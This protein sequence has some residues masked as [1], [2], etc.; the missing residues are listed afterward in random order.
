VKVHDTLNR[1][2]RYVSHSTGKHVTRQ[3]SD[4]SIL[5]V[6]HRF[7][8]QTTEA[9]FQL[10]HPLY[11]HRRSLLY[12]L[13]YLRNE[14]NSDYGGPL[15]FYPPQQRRGATMPDNNYMVYDILPRGERLLK[16]ALLYREHHPTTNGYEWKH[17]FMAV[18]IMASVAIGAKGVCEFIYPDE[19]LVDLPRCFDVPP[20]QYIS[21][22][23]EEKIRPDA[24]LRPDGFFALRYENGIKRIFLLEADCHTEPY[25]SDN[26]ERKSLKHTILAYYAL[27]SNGAIRRKYFGDARVGVLNLFTH[28]R[29]MQRAMDLQKE[30][31]ADKGSRGPLI[32]VR[33]AQYA[34]R[35]SRVS[36]FCAVTQFH[37][38]A[39]SVGIFR[40][41]SSCR[42]ASACPARLS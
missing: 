28:P 3:P 4:L 41:Q 23:G 7:G 40:A 9:I 22:D 8:P 24:V 6:L 35:A 33:A 31:V 39:R 37:S 34:R 18:T 1:R 38:S 13:A 25:R 27:F 5:E 2:L 17:D 12:R 42:R 29:A 14:E 32:H 19:V 16:N 21:R 36:A 20:Y 26:L 15:V 10:L 30:L 11:G